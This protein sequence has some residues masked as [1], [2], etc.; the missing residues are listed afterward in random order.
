MQK[1]I[2]TIFT[3]FIISLVSCEISLD[4]LNN[5]PRN[6]LSDL[7]I[8]A[9]C[10]ARD[11]ND[12][13]IHGGLEDYAFRLSKDELIAKIDELSKQYGPIIFEFL[14]QK[15]AE[16]NNKRSH[17]FTLRGK[18]SDEREVAIQELSNDEIKE[19]LFK[20][21]KILRGSQIGNEP[22]CGGFHDYVWRFNRQELIEF[23]FSTL[24]EVPS[25]KYDAVRELLREYSIK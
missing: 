11:I 10:Y 20:I 24:G 14:D 1:A 9:Q 8:A 4:V 15:L 19:I 16:L 23:F 18:I 22:I 2:K 13:H 5:L 25:E 12:E 21:E 3:V 17:F 6:R 7:A